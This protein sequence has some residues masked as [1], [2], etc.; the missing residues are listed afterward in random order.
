M[1]TVIDETGTR[2]LHN[3][4]VTECA[5]ADGKY[6]FALVEES[7]QERVIRELREENE[8]MAGAIEELAA[9]IGGDE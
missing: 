5:S 8:L 6:W 4:N 7:E 3:V 2:V 9:I 1:V